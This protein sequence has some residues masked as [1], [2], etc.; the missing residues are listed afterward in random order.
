MY[1]TNEGVTVPR[2]KQ[3]KT[4]ITMQAQKAAITRKLV[5]TVSTRAPEMPRMTYFPSTGMAA[6]HTAAMSRRR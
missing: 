6:I 2:R 4:K 3:G 1:F 5:F